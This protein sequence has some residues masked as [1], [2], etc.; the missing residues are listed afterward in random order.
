MGAIGQSK[1]L[2]IIVIS[3][4]VYEPAQTHDPRIVVP[5]RAAFA[6]VVPE[7]FI[8]GLG[9]Y[10]YIVYRRPLAVCFAF[11]VWPAMYAQIE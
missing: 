7:L 5:V 2:P 1:L 11:L 8:G 3:V 6:V 4:I 10:S 9:P